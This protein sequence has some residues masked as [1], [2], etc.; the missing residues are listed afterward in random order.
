MCIIFSIFI[1]FSVLKKSEKFLINFGKT[2]INAELS[3][4]FFLY[5]QTTK[6]LMICSG[7]LGEIS[8]GG[9]NFTTFP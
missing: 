4:V 9:V 6:I 2:L 8:V 3:T 5:F 1:G 7:N